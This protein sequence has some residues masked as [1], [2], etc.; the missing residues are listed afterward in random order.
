MTI[1]SPQQQQRQQPPPPP[2]LSQWQQPPPL[3]P[4]PQWQQPPPPPP[5]QQPLH[6]PTSAAAQQWEQGVAAASIGDR[7]RDLFQS[8]TSRLRGQSRNNGNDGDTHS[9]RENNRQHSQSSYNFNK[10]Q[11]SLR[12]DDEKAE[13]KEAKAITIIISTSHDTQNCHGLEMFLNDNLWL[14]MAVLWID[15][16]DT[17]VDTGYLVRLWFDTPHGSPPARSLANFNG[18][19]RVHG[20]L[21]GKDELSRIEDR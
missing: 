19:I 13:M 9:H 5:Q 6:D 14:G 1:T 4:L 11:L 10:I 17:V 3:P 15:F 8:V 20:R 18:G 7:A 12:G 21:G 2:P 16:V